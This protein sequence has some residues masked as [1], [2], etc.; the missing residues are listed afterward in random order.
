[1]YIYC[2]QDEFFHL[3]QDPNRVA[4]LLVTLTNIN[5]TNFYE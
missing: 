5:V 3:N 1:M 2:V 4:F